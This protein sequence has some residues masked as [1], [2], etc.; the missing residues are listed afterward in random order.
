M[1]IAVGKALNAY[2]DA[3]KGT[4]PAPSG[5]AE[6]HEP[7]FAGMLKTS[8]KNAIDDQKAAERLSMAAVAGKADINQVVTAVA[9]AEVTLQA[10]VAV[11][12]KVIEA[13]KDIIRM[14]I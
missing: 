13:Y 6:R 3:L 12:D 14:P 5:G 4:K 11:R 1:A 10:V 9:E 8:V 2:R 7:D